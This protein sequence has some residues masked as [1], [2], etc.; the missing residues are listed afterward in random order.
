[1]DRMIDNNTNSLENCTFVKTI[2]MFAVIFYHSCLFLSDGWFPIKVVSKAPVLTGIA[3][4]L[5]SF[6]IYA[7]VL[8]SGFIFCYI[9]DEKGEYTKYRDYLWKKV[10]RLVI[11]AFFTTMVWVLPIGIAFYHY[12]ISEVI[13]RY[14]LAQAP[15]Q[16][17]FL[18]MLFWVFVI[19]WP[20]FKLVGSNWLLGGGSWRNTIS[21][22]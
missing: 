9:K 20:L 10:K 22:R 1:M 16:L 7:F 18:W 12:D 19:S 6:H 2:L 5:N 21:A 17:W 15:N 4:W 13:T 3:D 8:V 14:I 11:P